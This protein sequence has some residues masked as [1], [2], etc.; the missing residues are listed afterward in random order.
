M[1]F[2]V[3]RGPNDFSGLIYLV[4]ILPDCGAMLD[5]ELITDKIAPMN[6][7]ADH[8][9]ARVFFALWPNV[10]ERQA[11]A[12]WQPVLSDLCGG[13]VM[14]A[15]SL[16]ATLVFLGE[17]EENRLEALQLAAAEVCVSPFELVFDQAHYWGHNHIVYAAPGKLPEKLAQLAGELA[18][19][20]IRHRFRFEQREYKPHVTLLRNARWSDQPLPEMRPVCW[21]AGEFV[22]LQS[23]PGGANYRILARFD[24]T[25][26]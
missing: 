3:F 22:L 23:E 5:P 16:H 4:R 19:S 14:R 11:L 12:G 18:R 6:T 21:Q 24:L 1:D 26:K 13:R 20:L 25:R 17:V 7:P 9:T 10:V 2:R 15:D 8:P